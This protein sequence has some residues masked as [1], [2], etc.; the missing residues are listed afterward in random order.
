M[1]CDNIFTNSL[2]YASPAH[3]GW[4]VLKA[5][6]LIP[7]SYH[8]FISPAACGR[9]GSLAAQMEGRRGTVS[10]L[11]LTE[12]SIVSGD[13]EQEVLEAADLLI[14]MR[15]GRGRRPKV[16][17]L[18]VSCIDD[19]LGTDLDAICEELGEKYPD[20]QFISCHMNLHHDGYG[21]PAG[22]QHSK[23]DLQR[24]AADAGDRYGGQHHRGPPGTA[25][26]YGDL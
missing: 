7:E 24:P 16:F 17:S 9:H 13:Y 25:S 20:I 18:F 19:L 15:T 26:G 21:R 4:G 22:G 10:Y 8:L 11:H 14:A 1:C 23:Q 5:G 12:E 2:H 6:Q 3:G